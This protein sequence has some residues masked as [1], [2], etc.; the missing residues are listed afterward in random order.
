MND[1]RRDAAWA[2]S[3][4]PQKDSLIGKRITK[5]DAPEKASGKT[6]YIHDL[7]L[8][9]QLTA[10]SCARPACTR[11]SSPSTPRRRSALPGVHAVITAADV[12]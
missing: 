12:P 3:S 1:S 10:R 6:R 5:L 4:K 11:R 9:G 2:S 8:P 7:D